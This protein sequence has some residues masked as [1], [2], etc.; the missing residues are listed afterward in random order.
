MACHR[1]QSMPRRAILLYHSL[2]DSPLAVSVAA[3]RA[4]MNWLAKTAAVVTTEDLLHRRAPKPLSL[5]V[6][7]D[8]GYAS[9]FGEA[10]PALNEINATATVF[11]NTGCLS[12]GERRA[13]DPALGHYP[14]DAFLLWREADALAERGWTMGSHGVD[15]LDFT[16]TEPSE[17]RR[18]LAESKQTIESRFG[19]P[20]DQFA[21]TWGRHTAPLRSAVREAGY[22]YGFAGTHG[23]LSEKTDAMAVPRIDVSNR[24]TLDDFKA[25]V[26]GDWDYLGWIQKARAALS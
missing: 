17:T 12:D 8:D 24:Y 25:I 15:H 9:V 19:G 16:R 13:S 5:A 23:P 11:L 2:G 3:F 4:Q 21:Y 26:H 22:R 6:S 7:F 1:V 10:F 14:D 20:C 18:Q